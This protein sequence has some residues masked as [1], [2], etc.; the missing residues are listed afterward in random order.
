M[1][2]LFVTS[3]M[4]MVGLIFSFT[5]V[6]ASSQFEVDYQT[7]SNSIHIEWESDAAS[8][9]LFSGKK[10]IWSGSEKEYTAENLKSKKQYKYLLVAL[11]PND[12]V[13]DQAELR[14]ITKGKKEKKSLLL[15]KAKKN[16]R[17][18]DGITIDAIIKNNKVIV[19]WDE[20][21]PDEDGAIDLYRNDEYL[22]QI[23]GNSYVDT[24]IE[25]GKYYTYRV[26]GEKKKSEEEINQS[27]K[28]AKKDGWTI[29]EDVLKELSYETFDLGKIVQTFSEEQV[30]NESV[31]QAQSYAIAAAIPQ[32]YNFRYTTFIPEAK[33]GIP[34]NPASCPT[35]RGDNRGFAF[36]HSRYR[37]Q[38]EV[39]AY[40]TGTTTG[41]ASWVTR[42]VGE[43][44]RYNC[45]GTTNY[46]TQTSYTMS[47][48]NLEAT[49][50]FVSWRV[51][52]AVGDPF[53]IIN[54]APPVIDYTYTANV[55]YD[56]DIQVF[57][58]HDQAPAHEMY[59]YI[60]NS[61]AML[62]IFQH[63]NKGLL[64]LAPPY[65]NADIEFSIYN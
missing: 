5:T 38:T 35:F 44:A 17:L 10:L 29:T 41:T 33:V 50:Q 25:P 45:D 43:S 56:G 24:D 14:V 61:D 48:T 23:K 55:S 11:D 30:T 31:E 9:K 58:E 16:E 37:T 4:L 62:P 36:D 49:S 22:G 1:K 3:I 20:K 2:K 19:K 42:D 40:L 47:K 8:F 60:P 59:V 26:Q 13:V 7:T 51:V 53:D 28:Q 57:G 64:Y 65:P 6:S 12:K 63:Q 34:G 52:H 27:V 32:R 46:K 15:Q 18:L 54:I 21:L 39:S